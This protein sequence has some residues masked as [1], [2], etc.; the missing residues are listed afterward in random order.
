M[1]GVRGA[2]TLSSMDTLTAKARSVAGTLRQEILVNGRHRLTTDQPVAAGGDDSAPSPHELL[3]AA[4]AACI[5]STL[6]VYA[7]TKAWE[8][9]DVTVDV[10][11]DKQSKP[12]RF[13]IAIH[14][15]GDLSDLQLERLRKVAQA[16]PLRRSIEA[17]FVFEERLERDAAHTAFAA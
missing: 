10:D 12:R 13:E 4:L 2:S 9:G 11:Y 15:S 8:L 6:T 3:P 17:G 7:R 16:C 5:A 1:H 14:V